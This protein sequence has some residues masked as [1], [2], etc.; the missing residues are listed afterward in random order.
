[1]VGLS[2]CSRIDWAKIY[3]SSWF[4]GLL[5]NYVHATAPCSRRVTRDTFNYSKGD[6]L[7][8]LLAY[9]VLPVCRDGGRLVHSYWFCSGFEEEA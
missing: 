5:A 3:H 8:Q 4:T 1:M 9:L 2:L 6:V 7:V